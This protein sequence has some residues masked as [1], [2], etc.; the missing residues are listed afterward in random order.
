MGMT[1]RDLL[2]QTPLTLLFFSACTRPSYNM[3]K[4]LLNSE[5]IEA[6]FGSYGI[7]VLEHDAGLRVSSLYS[8]EGGHK[9]CRTFAMVAYPATIDS[10]IAAEHREILAGGSIGAVFKK[11]GWKAN[12][13]HRYFGELPADPRRLRLF[14]LM[15]ERGK[16]K[17][18][19]HVYRM[20]LERGEESLD[21]AML[22]EVHHP[23][24]LDLRDLRG[25]YPAEARTLTRRD[26]EIEKLLAR[27]DAEMSETLSGDASED[28]ASL[29]PAAGG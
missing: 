7:E 25:I 26:A 1:R 2:V 27:V 16:E 8:L 21:Y 6:I 10:R 15:G 28:P 17:L 29:L 19:V 18:A 9:I 4:P 14:R 11:A 24:F 12:K 22:V 20:H 5:R 23:A 13:E 3:L